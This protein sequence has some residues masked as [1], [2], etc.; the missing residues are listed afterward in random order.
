MLTDQDGKF[1][2]RGIAPGYYAVFSWEEVEE[3]AW[4]DSEFLKPFDA[5]G[6]KITVQ[7]G[8]A[9]TMNLASIKAAAAPQ[10]RQ[11]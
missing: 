7:D 1:D 11:P 8:D 6:E 3:G 2:L 10:D 4:E 5:K 9:K